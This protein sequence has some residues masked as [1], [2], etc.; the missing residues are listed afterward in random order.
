MSVWLPV[1][2]DIAADRILDVFEGI[3]HIRTLRMAS[4]KFGTT[5]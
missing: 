2:L 5:N 1:K 3:I 4:R